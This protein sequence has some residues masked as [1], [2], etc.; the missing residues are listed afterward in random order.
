MP[1]DG[2][3][4]ILNYADTKAVKTPV[5]KK[6]RKKFSL[7]SFPEDNIFFEHEEVKG[8][9]FLVHGSFPDSA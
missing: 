9:E 8:D 3:T 4:S 6:S 2:H 7:G 5:V 1:M